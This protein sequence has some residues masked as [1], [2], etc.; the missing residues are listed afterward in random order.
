MAKKE[1]MEIDALDYLNQIVDF[2][3]GNVPADEIG[4]NDFST[5]PEA[6][7]KLQNSQ[8]DRNA[9]AT[10]IKYTER[11]RGKVVFLETN[12][13]RLQKLQERGIIR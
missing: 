6:L 4:V 8:G 5:L 11:L 3:V 1:G 13:L 12:L 7:S 2:C 10:A 9:V